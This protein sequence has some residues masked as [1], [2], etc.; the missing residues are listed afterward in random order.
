MTEV[1]TPL[2]CKGQTTIGMEGCAEHSVLRSDVVNNRELRRLWHDAASAA[3][4][5]HISAAEQAWQAYRK[6]ACLSES[7]AYAGGTLSTVIAAR[8]LARLTAARATEL[9]NQGKLG[10]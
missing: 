7:D 2:P 4:R 9:T 1:F 10:P 5:E 6:A 3:A 8:C